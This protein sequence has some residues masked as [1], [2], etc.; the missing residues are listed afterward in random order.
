LEVP[1]FHITPRPSQ[2]AVLRFPLMALPDLHLNY[3]H[4]KLQRAVVKDLL[5]T[6]GLSTTRQILPLPIYMPS[7]GYRPTSG[8]G[9]S[10]DDR[11]VKLM[12]LGI[13]PTPMT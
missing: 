8:S 13:N 9:I 5:P 3:L 6:H 12:H 4:K 11:E 7:R 10:K 1:T 2:L